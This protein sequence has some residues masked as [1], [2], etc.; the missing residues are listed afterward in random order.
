MTIKTKPLNTH[1][2]SIWLCLGIRFVELQKLISLKICGDLLKSWF[3]AHFWMDHLNLWFLS[4]AIEVTIRWCQGESWAASLPLIISSWKSAQLSSPR[5]VSLV[6]KTDNHCHLPCDA[7]NPVFRGHVPDPPQS[8]PNE[9]MN[10]KQIYSQ[11]MCN[12]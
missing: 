9:W 8:W 7:T 5:H 11:S 12:V 4:S 6:H 2:G 1:I 3:T 10:N